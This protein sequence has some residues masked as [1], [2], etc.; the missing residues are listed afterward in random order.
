MREL[1]WIYSEKIVVGL[2][3]NLFLS[4]RRKWN[5]LAIYSVIRITN[6]HV[7]EVEDVGSGMD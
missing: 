3:S 5:W 7:P 4:I 1:T 6:R 2:R